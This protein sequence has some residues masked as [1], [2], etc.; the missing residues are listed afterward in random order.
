MRLSELTVEVARQHCADASG[1]ICDGA[2]M[3]HKR[4]SYFGHKLSQDER[5]QIQFA[6]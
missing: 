6:Q 2:D 1:K 5:S 3:T 4:L